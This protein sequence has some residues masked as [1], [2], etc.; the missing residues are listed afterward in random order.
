GMIVPA[1]DVG[2]LR[3]GLARLRDAPP[4]PAAGRAAAAEAFS[5]ESVL[6]DYEAVFTKAAG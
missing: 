4:D 1:A 5:V 2:A 6:D 3:D